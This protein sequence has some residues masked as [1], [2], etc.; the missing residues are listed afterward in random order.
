MAVSGAHVTMHPADVRGFWN[1][2]RR[3][4]FAGLIVVYVLAP[5]LIRLDVE[6]RRF[7][8][9][10]Q[11]FNAQDFWLVLMLALAVAFSLLLITG[12]R[13]RAWCG[14]ACPQTVFLEGVY[15]PVE[16]FF[17]GGREARLRLQ[18]APMS[19]NKAAR[20]AAKYVTF[21]LISAAI[22][23]TA[24]AIFVG[25]RELWL[26]I[27]EGPAKHQLAFLLT[28]GFTAILTF[29]FTWFR[30]QFCVVLCP[31]GRLQSVLHDRDSVTVAY[32]VKRGEP[33]GKPG[34]AQGDCIDCKRCVAVCPTGI[35]IRNGLQMECLACTQCI[36]A[37]DEIMIKVHKP[38]GLIRFASQNELAG[39]PV[40]T[41]RPRLVVYGALVVV[42]VV[43]LI[44]A[45]G[46]RESFEA[47]VYRDRGAMP[48]VVE[49]ALVRN[50]FEVHVVNKG[51]EPSRF[52]IEVK[53][54]ADVQA[55]VGTPHIELAGSA[56][57]H[58]PVMLTAPRGAGP[59][60]YAIVIVDERTGATQT[61]E[62]RV[63]GR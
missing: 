30:E 20:R 13:G 5:A 52:S 54:P 63:L 11:S 1:R 46:M 59:I 51:H 41:I 24:S 17:D 2:R 38:V 12:W 47:N 3:A 10:G 31:Y 62:S 14:W 42:S 34:P 4:V 43:S 35:D 22:A 9:F 58:V 55:M 57:A 33:R 28:V 48:F 18:A 23:H 53:A 50:A 32:D 21:L 40:R 60:D 37:C 25:P 61:I 7:V 19:V 26:M 49:G 44:V 56:D 29:N 15:R 45:L 8:F 36:D 6:H 27:D 39:Q 16:H